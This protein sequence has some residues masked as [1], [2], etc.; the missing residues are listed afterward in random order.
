MIAQGGIWQGQQIV[1]ADW[2]NAATVPSAKTTADEYGYGYQWWIPQG[3]EAGEF[4]G[5][6]IYRQYIYINRRLNVVIA[7]N[8]ADTGFEEPGAEHRNFDMIRAIAN[9]L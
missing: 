7:V 8:S 5:I 2:I 9:S 6:G 3:W 1:P 4:T